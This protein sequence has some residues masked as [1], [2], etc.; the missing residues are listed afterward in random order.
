M[1]TTISANKAIARFGHCLFLLRNAPRFFAD[2]PVN[3]VPAV[4]G[5]GSQF[6]DWRRTDKE[7]GMNKWVTYYS[8]DWID[9]DPKLGIE[10]LKDMKV[11]VSSG[12][13]KDD[14]G[15]R[16]HICHASTDGTVERV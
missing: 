5:R 2:K 10:A 4:G 15:N 13:G 9:H 14:Y 11:Y 6:A 7:F 3:V 8:Q 1:A 12:S 16:M